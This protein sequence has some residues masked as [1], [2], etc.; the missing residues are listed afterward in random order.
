MTG[1]AKISQT[2]RRRE[3]ARFVT[4]S[5][6]YSD[7]VNAQGQAYAH[8]VRSQHAHGIVRSVDT[9]E[10][11][12][13]PGVLGV[14]TGEDLKA[15][16]IDGLPFLP[17]PGFAMDKPVETP[18]PALA[19]ERVRYVGEQVAL[20]VA[21][22]HLQAVDAAERVQVDIEPLPAVVTIDAA[23]APDACTLWPE[24]PGN[25]VL[26][27]EFGDAAK[28]EAA[29][30]RAAHVSKLKLVNNRVVANPMEPRSVL[31]CYDAAE[32]V[33]RL[34]VCSQGV[35]YY[36]RA[37]SEGTFRLAPNSVHVRTHDVGGAFGNKEFPYPEDI[38]VMHAARVLNVPVKWTGS[39]IEHLL[40]DNHA[41]EAMIECE[42]ALDAEG[43]FIAVRATVLTALGAYCSYVAPI[44]A[45]R[46]TTFGL[47]MAYM[48]PL[49]AAAHQMVVT[50]TAPTGP[51]RG[52][53]R[54]QCVLIVE[55]LI[56]QAARELGMDPIELRRRNVVPASAIPYRT[57]TGQFYESGDFEGVL[58]KAIAL[59]DWQGFKERARASQATGKL[60]GH[61][62]SLFVEPVGGVPF[63]GAHI[64]FAESGG[65]EA[66]V[67]TQS[68]GQGHETT[69]AQVIAGRL[70][71]PI[72]S[73]RIKQGDSFDVP[74]GMGSF[75]SRSMIMAGSALAVTCNSVIEKGRQVAAH[76]LGVAVDEIEFA[77]GIF[78]APQSNLTIDIYELAERLRN[79]RNLPE[80][81]PKSL[82]SIGEFTVKD[83]HYP[84][85]C[86]VCE[87]EIC[88]QTGIVTV[89]RYTA[90]D[91]VGRAV[92]SMIVHGQIHGGIAQGLGQALLEHCVYDK[93]GQLVTAS[94]ADYAMPRADHFPEPELAFHLAPSTTN[95]LGVKGCG[96]SGVT[97]SIAA[98]SNAVADALARAGSTRAIDMPFTPPKI[99]RA[100]N[101]SA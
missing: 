48:T 84:S 7:D 83:F 12:N 32:G 70:G 85:G 23:V 90:V 26:R 59:S 3:D 51:Y 53:G 30:A 50:N 52:A 31:A 88:P 100:L 1:A 47:P 93:S 79:F 21:E 86:H 28:I 69:F 22:S 80:G 68:Q 41:R 2:V 96:E 95:P 98:I 91:D 42:L 19:F 76:L 18:R 82:D 11:R 65:V 8:F 72:D 5:G 57:P 17:I 55:R 9:A 40:S 63:E 44:T 66:V 101:P 38:A 74:R 92:N 94:F 64:R 24:A 15:A 4:G 77:G 16:G 78:R 35:I 99:W 14:F 13:M 62:I 33:F 60:R 25:V 20:V 6:T 10:A 34:T 56:D 45:I 39:R 58:N 67:A 61:G 27:W 87:V 89:D 71:V 43:G 36:R 29:F 37:L 46:N 49:I 54:E 81:L 97:G 73:V 75:A